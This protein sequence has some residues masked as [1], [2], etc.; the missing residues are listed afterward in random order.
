MEFVAS[1]NFHNGKKEKK[2]KNK[3]NLQILKEEKPQQQQQQN[4]GIVKQ[5]LIKQTISMRNK[6]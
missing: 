3:M 6:K 1:F 4:M 5:C 2:G